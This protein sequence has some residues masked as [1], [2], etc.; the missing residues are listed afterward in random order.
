LLTER[1]EV[2]GGNS[3]RERLNYRR[4]KPGNHKTVLNYRVGEGLTGKW[5]TPPLQVAIVSGVSR[6]AVSEAHLTANT[7]NLFQKTAT[8]V[9]EHAIGVIEIN[10][11]RTTLW[12]LPSTFHEVRN[13][14]HPDDISAFL[15]KESEWP[16]PRKKN[17]VRITMRP[18]PLRRSFE[19][20]RVENIPKVHRSLD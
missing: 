7:F 13:S 12:F 6:N 4:G 18:T 8:M 9:L 2:N 11:D 16:H 1:V 20:Q 14:L 3:E 17:G 19:S 10:E 5:P 15:G